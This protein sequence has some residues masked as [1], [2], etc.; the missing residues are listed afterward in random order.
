MVLL[1]AMNAAVLDHLQQNRDV[2]RIRWDLLLR[3][4]PVVSPLA[5][6]D[7]MAHLIPDS[8]GLLMEELRARMQPNHRRP[9]PKRLACN[10]GHNPYR[11][12]FKAGEQ[13]LAEAV[14]IAHVETRVDS[15]RQADI[16][17]VLTAIRALA[18]T[19]INTFCSICTNYRVAEKCRYRAPGEA[20]AVA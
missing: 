17:E 7:T 13:A 8:I 11:A 9:S 2:I 6:P 4:E 19:E 1:G 16:T 3:L 20:T 12:Y 15:D 14:V 10:C 5:N 18:A